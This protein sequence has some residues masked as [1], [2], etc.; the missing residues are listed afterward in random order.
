V[1][2]RRPSGATG[3]P[4]YFRTIA[5]RRLLRQVA[6]V[7]AAFLVGYLVNVFWLFPAPLYSKDHAVPRLLDMGATEART[8]LEAQG[9]RVRV[10]DQQTDVGAPQGTVVWQD[11]PP[12]VV[13][14]PNSQVAIIVSEGPPDVPVPDV[15]GFPRL[16]AERVLAAAGFKIGGVDTLPASPEPGI[17]IQT[18]PAS[19]VGRPAGSPVT[20]VISSGPAEVTVPTVIGLPL[21]VARERLEVLGLALGTVTGRSAPGRVEGMVLEQRPAGGARVARTTKVDFIVTRKD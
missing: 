19:S 5:G 12:G 8:R 14:P 9:F 20:L 2:F 15:A 4:G 17:V 6:V 21:P 10:E 7:V 13:V 1:R 11:P 18:R 16:L 3:S